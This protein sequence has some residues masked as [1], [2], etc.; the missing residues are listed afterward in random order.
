MNDI[1]LTVVIMAGGQGK[2]MKS[3]LPKVLHK[4]NGIPFLVRIVNEAKKLNPSKIIIV[5]GKDE[6]LIKE[7]LRH[8]GISDE[9]MFVNQPAA[10]GTG[11]AV[12]CALNYIKKDA[13]VLILNGDMPLI[14]AHMLSKFIENSYNKSEANLEREMAGSI[15]IAKLE[16][17]QHYGR[18][19]MDKEK[20]IGILE[21]K[22]CTEE[23]RKIDLI[24]AG[25]YCFNGEILKKYIN[26][27]SNDNSQKEYYLTDII[28]LLVPDYNVNTYLLGAETNHQ[29]LG[30]NTKE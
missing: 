12:K 10:N 28:K 15:I 18:I 16:D 1:A 23:Q 8:Y 9:I 3:A 6:I 14:Q 5:V 21:Y 30:I 4:F 7:S 26:K 29:I 17:P 19:I 2:R 20:F 25:V 27:I 11:D 24:N 22:D 13:N